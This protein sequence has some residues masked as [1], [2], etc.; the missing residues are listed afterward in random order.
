MRLIT[1]KLGR[2]EI[3]TIPKLV[4][5]LPSWKTE[6][7]FPLLRLRRRPKILP[8]LPTRCRT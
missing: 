3:L 8:N 1:E 4:F 5:P 2:E 7:A 6:I